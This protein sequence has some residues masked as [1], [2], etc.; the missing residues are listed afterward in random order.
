VNET[1]AEVELKAVRAAAGQHPEPRLAGRFHLCAAI[2]LA[3]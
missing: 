1:T 2:S 3:A